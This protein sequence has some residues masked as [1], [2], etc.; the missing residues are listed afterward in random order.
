MSQSHIILVRHGEASAAWSVH[1][2]P[3]LSKLGRLQAENIGKSLI[4]QIPLYQLISSPKKRAV[5]TMELINQEKKYSFKLDHRFIEI[6]SDNIASEVKKD[7]LMSIFEAPIAKLPER[8]KD[9]RDDLIAWI[10][11]TDGNFIVTTHYMVINALISYL[12]SSESISYFHPDYASRTE[13][14]LKNGELTKLILGD[15][16]KTVINL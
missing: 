15:D 5:E 9:W 10:D 7:W 12:T 4:D 14:F 1:P 3:G 2:D 6:P 8:I 16:K 13:I 11:D